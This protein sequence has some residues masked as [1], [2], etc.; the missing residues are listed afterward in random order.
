M[1]AASAAT[2]AARTREWLALSATPGLGPTRIKRLL[3]RFGDVGQVFRASLTELEAAG[4]PAASAQSI[5]LGSSMQL[6]DE[7][8][9][10]VHAA[11]ATLLVPDDPAYPRQLLEIYDP[12]AVLRVRGDVEALS[13]P[14]IA[15]VGT[16]H[17]TP[18]GLGMAERLAC[19]LAARGLIIL[20]GMAR[21]VDSAA[22]RGAVNAR[23]KTVAVFGTGIDI[24]YPRENQKLSEQILAHGGTLISE[25]PMGAAPTP[26]NFPIRNRVISGL[27]RGVLVVEAGEY[28]GTRITARCALEQCRE[29]F[30]VPGNVTNKLAWGPNTL[31]KQGA[32]LVATWEDVWEELPTDIRLRVEAARPSA[33]NEPATASLFEQSPLA[34]NEKKVY[35][36]IKSD[37]AI[38]I[39]QL[40][41]EL[42]G[43]FSSS[44]IFAALFELELAARI[45]QLPGKNYVRTF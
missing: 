21:G 6:A 13:R 22:H 16:R 30:A 25:F 14:G 39:D 1:S 23:A 17:P 28:S 45:R 15:I 7:E 32:K 9:E 11:G 40:V 35:A 31:I 20:S 3:E 33:S 34:G 26:Q 38:H 12:P 29:V 36:L 27:S 4:I 19:D 18:Y 37:E 24:I 10:K 42:E 5:A 2:S 44:E 8:L 41:E 43:V